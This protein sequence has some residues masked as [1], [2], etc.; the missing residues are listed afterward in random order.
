MLIGFGFSFVMEGV[1]SFGAS[2]KIIT[3]VMV[4]LGKVNLTLIDCFQYII[5]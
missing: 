5:S 2:A 1:T 3:P 4:G